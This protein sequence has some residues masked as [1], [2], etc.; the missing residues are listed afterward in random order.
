MSP[1]PSLGAA[2][3]TK[4]VTIKLSQAEKDQLAQMYGTSYAGIR[5]GID[6]ALAGPRRAA[7]AATPT[8]QTAP[9]APPSHRHRRG[10]K[11]DTIYV[12]G[13]PVNRYRCSDPECEVIL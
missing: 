3:R 9:E 7:N 13:Q 10:N 11:I 4:S 12:Q 2:G 8:T 1:R 6:L 5:H